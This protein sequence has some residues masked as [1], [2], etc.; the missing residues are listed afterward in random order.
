VG[1][2]LNSIFA[3]DWRN[4]ARRWRADAGY[5]IDAT[6]AW[7]QSDDPKRGSPVTTVMAG[8][9]DRSFYAWTPDRPDPLWRMT[10]GNYAYSTMAV[11]R[12]DGEPVAFGMSWDQK[13]YMLDARTGHELWT[14][15]C[16]PLIWKHAWMGD[17]L[18]ASPVVAMVDGEPTVF[19]PAYDG[20]FYAY[21]PK[22]RK[23]G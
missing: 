2:R 20:V 14:A 22:L 21:R 18:W 16:G 17:S 1:S 13:L 8:S 12:L 6:P 9:Y 4:G 3:L 19:F 7:F 10:T 11:A 23:G 15:E 5:W